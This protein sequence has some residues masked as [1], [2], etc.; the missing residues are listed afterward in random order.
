MRVQDTRVLRPLLP[1]LLALA[2]AAASFAATVQPVRAQSAHYYSA[3][4]AAP[5]AAP[6]KMIQGGLPWACAGSECSAPRDSSRPA[7]VCARLVE[8][9]GAITRFATPK[10]ELAADDLARCNGSAG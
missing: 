10:G 3:T 7:I 9:V 6:K 4:L 2:G 8:K 1:A 5:V